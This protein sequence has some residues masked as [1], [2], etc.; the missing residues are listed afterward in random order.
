[1]EKSVLIVDDS[2]YTRTVIRNILIKEGYIIIGEAS[3]GE[4]AID[5]AFE[6][7]PDI[8]T[9]DIILPDMMGEDI[10][11]AYRENDLKSKII[12]I[13]AV[14]QD[15]LRVGELETEMPDY[16]EKPFTPEQLLESVD[17]E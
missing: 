11:K 2:L 4:N 8:I 13:T 15:S 9:L 16:I 7:Q 12:I 3:N 14:K 6:L 10:L 1:M 17:K 5:L